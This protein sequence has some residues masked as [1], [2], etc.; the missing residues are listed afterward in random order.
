MKKVFTILLSLFLLLGAA[1][2]AFALS[3][4]NFGTLKNFQNGTEI[5]RILSTSEL[6]IAQK[7]VRDF[8]LSK[9]DSTYARGYCLG[10]VSHCFDN[11]PGYK[12]VSAPCAKCAQNKW[13]IS[14]ESDY[15][16]IPIGACIYFDGNNKM[17]ETCSEGHK[18]GHVGIYV[19]DGYMVHLTLGVGKKQKIDDVISSWGNIEYAGWGWHGGYDLLQY[20]ISESYGQIYEITA[21]D[22]LAIRSKGDLNATEVGRIM[23]GETT[24]V[25]DYTTCSRGWKWGYTNYNGISG[26]I[27]LQT[28]AKY[29]GEY[30][31]TSVDVANGI[32]QIV[33]ALNGEKSALDISGQSTENKA[34]VHLWTRHNG[35]SQKFSIEK[36]GDYY[37]ITNINSGKVLDV[38]G[39][40]N[41]NGTNVFQYDS[42]GS[43]NQQWIF[44]DAGDGYYYIKSLVGAYLDISD[45]KSEDGTNVQVWEGNQTFSQKFKL[46]PTYEVPVEKN[47]TLYYDSNGGIEGPSPKTV[48]EGNYVSISGIK[49][50]KKGYVFVGWADSQSAKTADYSAADVIMLD[51]DKIIYAV[52]QET[53]AP[54]TIV[55]KIDSTQAIVCGKIKY[56]DVPPILVNS[57][58]MLPARFVA[59]NLGAEVEWNEAA[60]CVIISNDDT[61]IEIYIDS[62]TAYVNGEA[63]Y[64]DSPA[65][66]YNSRTYTPVR[67]ICE[68]LG[69]NVEWDDNQGKVTIIKY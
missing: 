1:F 17:S 64:L 30:Y 65:F 59:E 57:R 13:L 22:F 4:S 36:I 28:W 33:S 55:L 9:V 41:K 44:E 40:G 3:E 43:N 68:S 27:C 60:E 54:S 32:Y 51:D 15:S 67:F 52:W 31:N 8:A 46:V 7:N 53:D 47:Y 21:S 37:R 62:D 19:G 48:K 61:V 18:C 10:F 11:L 39:A 14:T 69:A 16:K 29:V 26:W 24:V 38:D 23:P 49:P 63:H 35:N 50:T 58:T 66:L 45:G 12:W 20:G 42:Q 5:K 34:N 25:T 2:P 56:N 6:T